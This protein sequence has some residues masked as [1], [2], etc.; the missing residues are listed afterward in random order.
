M[1]NY[2][3]YIQ[4]NEHPRTINSYNMSRCYYTRIQVQGREALE[5]KVA[6]LREAGKII[7]EIRTD[8]GTRIELDFRKQTVKELEEAQARAV[9]L[10]EK[11]QD[12]Q[13]RAADNAEK[14]QDAQQRAADNAT[15]ADKEPEI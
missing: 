13:Q 4:S 8:L 6:E 2:N 10:A 11:L 14:Q 5:K 9:P 7:S 15:K 1:K 12:A 3:I